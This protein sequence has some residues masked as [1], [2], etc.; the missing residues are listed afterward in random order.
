MAIHGKTRVDN[1]YWM[2][3][4][5][6]PAVIEYLDAENVYT[7]AVMAHTKPL[8]E[9]L[10][11][12]MKA[13]LVEEDVTAPYRHGD[14]LYYRKYSRTQDYPVYYRRKAVEGSEEEIL[15]DVNVIAEGHEFFSTAG[16]KVS[17]DHKLAA[18]GVDTVGRRFFTLNIVNL[19]TGEVI[20]ESVENITSNF[21]WAGDNKTLYYVRQNPQTL[22]YEK[23]YRHKL[24]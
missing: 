1:Y 10:F 21:V 4:R 7:E 6:N 2:N 13:R 22:T 23:V 18:Y 5:E 8:Q 12:E 16:F 9:K 20:D 19:E 17:P 24:G 11:E 14:Y 3:Q 15:L